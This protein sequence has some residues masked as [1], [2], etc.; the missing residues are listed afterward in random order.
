[1]EDGCT[2]RQ[3]IYTLQGESGRE[4]PLWM[5]PNPIRRLPRIY[6]VY[7]C[8]KLNVHY[9]TYAELDLYYPEPN[10]NPEKHTPMIAH[11]NINDREFLS[12]ANFKEFNHGTPD[13]YHTGRIFVISPEGQIYTAIIQE[14]GLPII[15][16]DKK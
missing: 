6:N 3:L 13:F 1:M 9:E 5:K 12:A 7:I 11:I 16:Q 14:R 15:F 4:E 8:R 2:Y 10:H